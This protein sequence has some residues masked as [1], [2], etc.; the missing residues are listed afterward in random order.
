MLDYG[1]AIF[2]LS[3]ISSQELLSYEAHVRVVDPDVN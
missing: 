2:V 3:R 1:H